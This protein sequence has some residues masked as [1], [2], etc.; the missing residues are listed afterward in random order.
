MVVIASALLAAQVAPPRV[1][2]C[3]YEIVREYPHD[4]G[5][6]T[7]GLFFHEGHLFEGTGQYGSSR[8]ARLELATGRALAQWRYPATE[9]GE[10]IVR[11][12]DQIIAVTWQNALG[13]RLRLTDLKPLGTFKLDGEGWGTTMLGNRLVLSDGSASLRF[14]DP[15]TMKQ[16]GSIDVTIAG[17]P[18]ARLN[19]LEAVGG[20]VWANVWMSEFIV[21]IDPASGR[22]QS[23]ID[24]RG[25]RDRAG[26][27]G[28]D[29]V[30]NGIAWDAKGSRL[31]V[32]GKNWSKLFQIRLTA[33]R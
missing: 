33:C 29:S 4:P 12:K 15:A 11:W 18:L 19:E 30:M 25:L 9:F 3:G 16:S 6:F 13:R 21:R 1:P 22:V 7:Q 32:T 14:F 8:I 5:S 17:K 24:L 20:E 23:V 28:I 31:F 2:V 27:D 10:G 26:A